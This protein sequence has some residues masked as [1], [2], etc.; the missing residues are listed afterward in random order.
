MFC[1]IL[2]W[3]KEASSLSNKQKSEIQSR[4]RRVMLAL[5]LFGLH[6]AKY[7]VMLVLWT[8][9]G[10]IMHTVHIP[11]PEMRNLVVVLKVMI[12]F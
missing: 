6:A 9:N 4:Q 1:M 7:E 5:Q 2:L 10:T 3:K 11:I 12:R 8:K